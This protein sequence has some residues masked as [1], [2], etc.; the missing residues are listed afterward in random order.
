LTSIQN[1]SSAA[2]IAGKLW[3]AC[4]HRPIEEFRH[5]HRLHSDALISIR[6]E[7]KST[8]LPEFRVNENERLLEQ[9]KVAQTKISILTHAL[10]EFLEDS[11]AFYRKLVS[12]VRSI[13]RTKFLI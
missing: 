7:I 12:E 4:F 13:L 11:I 5:A 3:K 6:N 8:L 2:V 9:E 10:L 1:I